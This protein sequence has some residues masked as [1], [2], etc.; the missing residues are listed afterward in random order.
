MPRCAT[1]AEPPFAG[2]PAALRAAPAG[3]GPRRGR[4]R[5]VL[6]DLGDEVIGCALG[7]EPG[8]PLCGLRIAH[9]DR[10][11][12]GLVL[13]HDRRQPG[14]GLRVHPPHAVGVV[15]HLAHEGL[16][17]AVGEGDLDRAVEGPVEPQ[18]RLALAGRR[19]ARAPAPAAGAGGRRRHVQRPGGVARRQ[20]LE[21]SGD[22]VRRRDV[23]DG[24]RAHHDP[25]PGLAHRQ[26]L[27]HQQVQRLTHRH[28]GDVQ[29]ARQ[30]VDLRRVRTRSRRPGSAPQPPQ[31]LLRRGVRVFVLRPLIRRRVGDPST[32]GG[33]SEAPIAL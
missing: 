16:R 26:P 25:P 27:H 30:V 22:V 31:H 18:E 6:P 10:G 12:D 15:A 20:P 8:Q 7:V 17:P 23:G 2:A 33:G 21:R 9:P 28:M 32:G 5:L 3:A 19:R 1:P 4:A 24:E 14:A 11:D 29:G 13:G